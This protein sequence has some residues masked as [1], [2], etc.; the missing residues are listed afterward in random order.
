[1]DGTRFAKAVEHYNL[2][3]RARRVDDFDAAV[4]ELAA[5]LHE[6]LVGDLVVHGGAETDVW[7][8]FFSAS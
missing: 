7:R 4:S 6:R 1:M 2:A 8:A 3:S 5:M